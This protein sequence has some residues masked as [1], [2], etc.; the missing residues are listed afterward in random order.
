MS[1]LMYQGD[2]GA[3]ACRIHVKLRQPASKSTIIV[4]FSTLQPAVPRPKVNA[5]LTTDCLVTVRGGPQGEH[6]DGIA[7]ARRRAPRCSA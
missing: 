5:N 6:W 4:F 2:I 1:Q 7:T 3:V